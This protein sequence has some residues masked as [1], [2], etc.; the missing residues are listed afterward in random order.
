MRKK[1]QRK[2][3][4]QEQPFFLVEQWAWLV[5][6]GVVQI[7]GCGQYYRRGLG[8]IF[9]KQGISKLCMSQY[10]NCGFTDR[11]TGSRTERTTRGH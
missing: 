7:S 1:S 6:L 9:G 5:L 4:P 11:E 10:V 3:S 8:V 2:A